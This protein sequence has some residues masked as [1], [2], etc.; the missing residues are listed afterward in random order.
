MLFL[1]FA[2]WEDYHTKK[3]S[4]S[5]IIAALISAVLYQIRQNGFH[6]LLFS[7]FQACLV[8]VILFPLYLCRSLGAG[9]IKLLSITAIFLSCR[10]AL[11]AFL[12]SMYFAFI[13]VTFLIFSKKTYVGNK[14]PMSGPILGGI[15]LVLYKEG[16]I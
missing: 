16:Y 15:L 12:S 6:N 5:L 3:I 4:N 10:H 11:L 13:P 1:I 8:I 7:L 2:V 9:D 14:I